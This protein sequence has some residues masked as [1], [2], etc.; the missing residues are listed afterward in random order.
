MCISIDGTACGQKCRGHYYVDLA[1]DDSEMMVGCDSLCLL[2]PGHT[3]RHRCD[4]DEIVY[5]EELLEIFRR[6]RGM[7]EIKLG[8]RN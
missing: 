5:K 1:R 6:A 7:L 3:G 8:R 2:P 4:L